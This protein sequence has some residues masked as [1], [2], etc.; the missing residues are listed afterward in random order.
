M[1]EFPNCV[2]SN[3]CSNWFCEKP[4]PWSKMT[5]K[6]VRI[7]FASGRRKIIET[8]LT[9]QEAQKHCSDPTTSKS[10]VWFDAYYPEQ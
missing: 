2:M 5:Y 9:L 4:T 8:G 3:Q 10:K 1:C 6:I 7:Y